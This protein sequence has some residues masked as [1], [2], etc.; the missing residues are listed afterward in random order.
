MTDWL[1]HWL[2]SR[3][4]GAWSAAFR[5][6]RGEPTG[7]LELPTARLQDPKSACWR[8]LDDAA[9]RV[10]P[11]VSGLLASNIIPAKTAV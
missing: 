2:P 6:L 8:E 9:R 11:Q 5:Q 1:P 7:R 3:I 4:E 10:Y